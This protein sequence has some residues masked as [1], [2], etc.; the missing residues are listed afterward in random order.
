MLEALEWY[1][2]ERPHVEFLEFEPGSD[3][4]KPVPV[5]MIQ[6]VWCTSVFETVDAD[7]VML[8]IVKT[9]ES[10]PND[11]RTQETS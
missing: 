1:A 5:D 7:L 2:A 9:E 3:F 10:C 11:K 6:S 4:F 8:H